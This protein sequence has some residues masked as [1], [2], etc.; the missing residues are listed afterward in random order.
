MICDHLDRNVRTPWYISASNGKIFTT[1][2]DCA[3]GYS[4][5]YSVFISIYQQTVEPSQIND[6]TKGKDLFENFGLSH[7]FNVS[8]SN[9]P[10][11]SVSSVNRQGMLLW[12]TPLKS[13]LVQLNV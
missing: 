3:W 12:H 9:I 4:H 11:N 6:V 8:I 7:T 1:T 5:I 2:N 10:Y 13:L